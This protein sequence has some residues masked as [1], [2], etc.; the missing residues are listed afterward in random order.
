MRPLP[1]TTELTVDHP[2][3]RVA[4]KIK[5]AL[6]RA[7]ATMIGFQSINGKPNF[8]RWVFS[9]A[10]NVSTTHVDEV[11]ERIDLICI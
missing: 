8:F 11:P 3:H 7:G 9:S 10:A 2:V 1:P 6:Q 4:P 5:A